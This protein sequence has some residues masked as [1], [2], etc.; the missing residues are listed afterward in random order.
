MR[1]VDLGLDLFFAMSGTRRRLCRT[2]RRIGAA[3]EM[4][5]HQIRF[6]V[7]QGTGVRFFLR[8]THRGQHV[9]NFLAFDL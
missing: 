5:P 8:D 7:L 9:K 4:L 2:R 3:A 6:K 1:E